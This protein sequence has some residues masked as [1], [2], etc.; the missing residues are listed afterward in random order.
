MT[1]K[2]R[3]E[4]RKIANGLEAI[5]QVGKDGISPTLI[6]GIDEALTKR[7]ILKVSVLE[8]CS[9]TAKEAANELAAATGAD[10]IQCIGR[11]FTLYRQNEE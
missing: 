11:K 8:T 5:Y 9:L 6:N 3:A 7:E 2:E 10:V 4:L 1:G